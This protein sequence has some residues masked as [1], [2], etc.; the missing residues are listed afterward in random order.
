VLPVNVPPVRERREDVPAL[1]QY[2][3]GRAAAKTGRPPL[4]VEETAMRLLRD[5]DWP[6]NVRELENLCER[7]SVLVLDGILTVDIV[8]PWLHG[9]ERVETLD[10]Q[11]RPGHILEDME[12]QLIEK[13]LRECGGHRARTAEMLGIGVRTLGLK[14]KLWRDE[15]R[16]KRSYQLSA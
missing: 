13:T 15:A 9:I 8:S 2:F 5:Y 4:R 12:R 10:Q 3:L 14:L 11:L 7:A 1:V 16:A 6:G